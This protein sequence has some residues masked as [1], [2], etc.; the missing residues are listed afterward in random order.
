MNTNLRILLDFYLQTLLRTISG[1]SLSCSKMQQN[2]KR[3][4]Y[5]NCTFAV[6]CTSNICT[7]DN[8]QLMKVFF[9]VFASI[10]FL[11]FYQI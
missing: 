9:M 8:K 4:K 3:G 7:T 10:M 5:A 1:F 6:H 2:A 11:C